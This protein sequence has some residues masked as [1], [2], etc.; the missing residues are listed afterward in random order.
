[1]Q[2]RFYG[3]GRLSATP[4]FESPT[5]WYGGGLSDPSRQGAQ[6]LERS[7]AAQVHERE[8]VGRG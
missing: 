8:I 4:I 6:Q 7:G 2:A 3:Y 5:S 1:M